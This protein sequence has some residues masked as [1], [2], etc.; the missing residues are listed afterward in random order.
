[1]SPVTYIP[2]PLL[3]LLM[4]APLVLARVG[5]LVATAPIFGT[6]EVPV[7]IR[8][9]IAV[10]IAALIVPLQMTRTIEL[11]EHLSSYFVCMAADLLIGVVLGLGIQLLFAGM[12]IAGQLISQLSGLQMADVLNPTLDAEVPLFSQ[13]LFCVALAVFAITGGHRQVME[14]LL[15]TFATI[16]PG[17][18]AMP[19]NLVETFTSLLTQSFVLGIR[20][21][22]PTMTA[23]LLATLVL[24]IISRSVPQLNVMAVGFGLNWL[25]TLGALSLTLGVAAWAFQAQIEPSLETLLA[26]LQG[27]TTSGP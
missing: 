21:A 13:M 16:P 25:V 10:A 4:V 2:Q 3:S 27:T 17:Q 5:G 20:A 24:G 6:R 7:R 11:P 9:L 26:T 8:A 12:Q 23:L 14:A 22:A 19:Q 1:V 18:L 15:D